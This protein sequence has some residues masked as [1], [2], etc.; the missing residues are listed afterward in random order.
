[1]ADDSASK[2]PVAHGGG[3]R[4]NHDWWPKALR[5]EGLNQHAPRSNPM[6][7]TFDYAAAFKALDLDAVIADLHARLSGSRSAPI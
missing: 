6:G 4:G 5:L 2:C 3:R 7:A 1:M